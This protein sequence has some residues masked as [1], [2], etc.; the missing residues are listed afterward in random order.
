VGSPFDQDAVETAFLVWVTEQH[1]LLGRAGLPAPGQLL[2]LLD[3]Y[4][5]R[6]KVGCQRGQQQEE[7]GRGR[8]FQ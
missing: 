6:I 8:N 7:S 1:R 3:N 4:V 5:L 2:G